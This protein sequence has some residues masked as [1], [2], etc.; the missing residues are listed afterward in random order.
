M[1]KLAVLALLLT[2]LG[3]GCTLGPN[4][5]RP[6]VNVPDTYR[7]LTPEE[8]AKAEAASLGDQKWWDVFQDDEL[9]KLIRT[10][11]QQN[12]D[13][14]IAAVHILEAQATGH[15]PL[16]SISHH[17]RGRRCG[18]RTHSAREAHPRDRHQCDCVERIFR[19]GTRLLGTVSPRHGSRSSQSPRQ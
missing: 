11:L 9:R 6:T 4:Y 8:A 3:A 19:L 2:C 16:E 1:R 5:K 13:V 12:Y 17:L 10:A 18:E 15:H 7:G 14:R